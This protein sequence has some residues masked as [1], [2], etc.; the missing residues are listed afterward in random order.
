MLVIGSSAPR[1]KKCHFSR[2]PFATGKNNDMIAYIGINRIIL[3]A[4]HVVLETTALGM[5]LCSFQFN[6]NLMGNEQKI[7]IV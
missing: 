2:A 4:Y 6:V 1:R 7:W 3:N 5:W